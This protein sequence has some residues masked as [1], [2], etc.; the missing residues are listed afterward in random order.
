MGMPRCQRIFLVRHGEGYHNESDNWALEDPTLTQKGRDQAQAL[1]YCRELKVG[2]HS[3]LV[4]SPLS[5]AI[6][7]ARLAY[8]RIATHDAG[9]RVALCPLHSERVSCPCDSGRSK[10][11][12]LK[13]YPFIERWDGFTELCE[14]WTQ[15]WETDRD[16][17][18]KRVPA[19][20]AWLSQQQ[21]QHIVVIGHG[22][23]FADRNLSAQHLGN[24][25][26][27]E[28][29]LKYI[30][31]KTDDAAGNCS[32]WQHHGWGMSSELDWSE[33]SWESWSKEWLWQ[34]ESDWSQTWHQDRDSDWNS[35]QLVSDSS[36][37]LRTQDLVRKYA[38]DK[39]ESP[40][41]LPQELTQQ[42][43]QDIRSYIFQARNPDSSDV[44]SEGTADGSSDLDA[45]VKDMYDQLPK[46]RIR[47]T[48]EYVIAEGF[49]A[50]IACHSRKDMDDPLATPIDEVLSRCEKPL[51]NHTGCRHV[52]DLTAD[53]LNLAAE[54]LKQKLP[55]NHFKVIAVIDEPS[56]GIYDPCSQELQNISALLKPNGIFMSTQRIDVPA[57]LPGYHQRV[58]LTERYSD[59]KCA[60]TQWWHL[61]EKVQPGHKRKEPM[62]AD[63]LDSWKGGS[64]SC[65]Q[66]LKE[67]KTEWP[68]V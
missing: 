50:L 13:D 63:V 55:L 67:Q 19:F 39:S 48:A 27:A 15:T 43:M 46:M 54:D 3:L 34:D 57:L 49:D 47:V 59:G 44:N 20:L 65:P 30:S 23:F 32:D 1:S 31:K 35:D 9:V 33:W 37:E 62:P 29:K 45:L 56:L 53:V 11:A 66:S 28:L 60:W 22:A 10:S 61:F 12:L 58:D 38:F 25:Q 18:A 24:C 17:R 7:T 42:L 8:P 16:W 26:F 4:V 40:Q 52:D 21:E 51:F 2:P 14:Q 6:E 5:R 68:A 41:G 36:W 64:S